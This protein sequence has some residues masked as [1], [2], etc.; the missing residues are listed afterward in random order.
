M[1]LFSTILA[2][3]AATAVV[4]TVVDAASRKKR[5]VKEGQKIENMKL[6]K[7]W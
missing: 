5:G 7:E 6:K 4:S 2:L 1:F 3:V